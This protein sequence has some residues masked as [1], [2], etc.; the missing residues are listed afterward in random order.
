VGGVTSARLRAHGGSG[1][2]GDG[3][4]CGACCDLCGVCF[5]V[6]DVESVDARCA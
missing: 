5:V 1:G 3:M 2:V 6:G 4:E